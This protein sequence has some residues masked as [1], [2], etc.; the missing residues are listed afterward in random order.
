MNNKY[1]FPSK[2][3]ILKL[4]KEMLSRGFNIITIKSYTYHI[5]SLLNLANKSPREITSND[6]ISY[7]EKL[8]KEKKSRSTLNTAH[9]ALKFYFTQVLRRNFF[10]PHGKIGRTKIKK[11]IP[12][13]PTNK[14][15]TKI[16]QGS[17]EEKYKLFFE[18]LYKTGTKTSETLLLKKSD[19]DLINK[20]IKIKEKIIKI[21]EKTFEKIKIYI[22]D[23]DD[24]E[25]LFK[26]RSNK[27]L[28]ER[29]VQK[30]FSNILKENKLN[31]DFTP[32]SFRYLFVF[33]LIKEGRSQEEIKK[34][35]GHKFSDT[36]RLYFKAFNKKP[37]LRKRIKKIFHPKHR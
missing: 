32:N 8:V 17:K 27:Q 18:L 2:D 11:K 25:L 31:K 37:I 22:V 1:K 34:L 36:I 14:E 15:A 4:K 24:Q 6:I 28:S 5:A 10:A 29:S 21:P 33:N 12:K 3:P 7:L 35:L 30:Y 23:L 13:I 26:N 16:I 19:L 20:S 9:S